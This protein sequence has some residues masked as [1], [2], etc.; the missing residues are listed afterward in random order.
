MDDLFALLKK[1]DGQSFNSYQVLLNKAFYSDDDQLRFIHIQG[2]TG[3]LPAS[4]CRLKLH[5]AEPGLPHGA[6][7]NGPRK[8]AAAD[9]ILRAFDA[10]VTA[11]ARQNRGVQGSGSFQ[12]LSLPPQVLERNVVR[13]DRGGV[14]IA[15]HVSLPGSKDNR[16]LGSQAIQMFSKELIGII[17]TLKARVA[18]TSLLKR[19]CDVIEDMVLLQNELNRYGLVAFVGDG[20]ILP[21]QSGVSQSPLKKGA[22]VFH[23]PDQMAVEVELKNAGRKR[24]LGVRPGVNVLVGGGF[25]GKSTL[26]DAL[27]KG[28]YPHIPGDGRE[29][30]VTHPEAA[31]VCA[32]EGRAVNGLDISGFID[33]LPG[34]EDAGRFWTRN[35]SGSS[36]Q[37]AAIIEAVLAG[38]KLLLIDE[39]SSATNFLIKDANMRKLIPQDT[40][41]PLFDRIRELYGNFGVSSLIVVGGSSEY[42][43]VAEHVIAMQNYQPVCMTDRVKQLSLAVPERPVNPLV[44]SDKRRVLTDNFNPSYH[45]QRLDKTLPVRIKPL[46]LQERILEY[47]DEKLDLIKLT[48]LVDP[49]QVLAIGYALLLAREKFEDRLLSPSDLAYELDKQIEKKGLSILSRSE[50]P[51]LFL[52]FPRRLELAGAINRLRNLKVD[53]IEM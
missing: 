17:N 12:P 27:A 40:I 6:I 38:A 14:E 45:A 53:I 23:A 42:L 22:V 13:F 31:F 41:T 35:A 49:H 3:A 26:L 28:I 8:M 24:G 43:G 30:V 29:Q 20:A 16:I 15:F 9:Y 37:A 10:G 34:N 18:K 51:P 32:E 11:H 46:R 1:L 5:A 33:N 52:A 36:S 48:Q 39:D 44:L 25:H 2:S 7:S 50:G 4:V 19:H 21:R 47:G